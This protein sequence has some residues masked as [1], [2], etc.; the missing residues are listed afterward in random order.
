MRLA[1]LVASIALGTSAGAT[2]R[3]GKVV[4]IERRSRGPDGIP[5]YCDVRDDGQGP[6]GTCLGTQ[7]TLG[8]VVDMVDDVRVFAQVRIT[9]AT[10]FQNCK[11]IW[12]IKGS[13]QHGDLNAVGTGRALGLI[14]GGLDVRTAHRI[15]NDLGRT[16]PSGRT[17]ERVFA[18]VDRDG[19]GNEDVVIT[20]YVCDPQGQPNATGMAQCMDVYSRTGGRLSRAQ[21]TIIAGCF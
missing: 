4:R 12:T 15:P 14:D 10:L 20:Q 11:G 2:P 3:A 21:Q 9:E 17:D 13:L 1:V 6:V 5:R 8:A 18:A 7:P 16:A 19:K